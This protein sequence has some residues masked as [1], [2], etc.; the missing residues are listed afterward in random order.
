MEIPQEARICRTVDRPGQR[1]AQ[2]ADDRNDHD[3]RRGLDP[4]IDALG[5]DCG[6]F[7]LSFVA[8]DVLYVV[9]WTYVERKAGRVENGPPPAIATEP[10]MAVAEPTK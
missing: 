3:P 5:I 10:Y 6:L 7:T 8:R 4:P 2:C 1:L 9:D